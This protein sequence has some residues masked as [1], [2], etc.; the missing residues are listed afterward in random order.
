MR[1][2]APVGPLLR[3]RLCVP[4]LP[5]PS[6]PSPL[7][8]R[9]PPFVADSDLLAPALADEDGC[10]AFW[11]VEDPDKPLS[12]RTVELTDV[13]VTDA[14][15][16]RPSLWLCVSITSSR[17]PLTPQLP[18]EKLFDSGALDREPDAP[19]APGGSTP[20]REPVFKLSWASFPDMAAVGALEA[21]GEVV[22]AET[23]AF[24]AREETV[25]GFLS[26][27][28]GHLTKCQS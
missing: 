17:P 21:A 27:P 1:R 12:V 8:S 7:S 2:L 10:I 20:R 16:V 11:A 22:S 28:A 4:L 9:R 14:E 19:R 23:K 5:P 24:A 13:N 15:S 18:T 3:R 25:R 6:P 26:G